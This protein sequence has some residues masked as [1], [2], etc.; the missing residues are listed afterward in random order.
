MADGMN[1]PKPLTQCST[2]PLLHYSIPQKIPCNLS[3]RFPLYGVEAGGLRA[4]AAQ[5]KEVNVDLQSNPQQEQRQ[6]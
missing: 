6:P 1:E 5:R 2:T 4:K 3:P